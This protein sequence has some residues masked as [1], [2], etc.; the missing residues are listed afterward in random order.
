M[1]RFGDIPSPS[2]DFKNLR[3]NYNLIANFIKLYVCHNPHFDLESNKCVEFLRI[4][5]KVGVE[6]LFRSA[7]MVRHDLYTCLTQHS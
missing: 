2:S 1:L 7:T 6:T 3:I 5:S 4:I